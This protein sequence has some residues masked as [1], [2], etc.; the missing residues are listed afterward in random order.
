MVDIF[1][2]FLIINKANNLEIRNNIL[3]IIIRSHDLIKRFIITKHI[4]FYK[5]IIFPRLYAIFIYD[6]I[7]TNIIFQI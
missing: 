1:F 4:Q 5:K 2:S 6:L 3:F 7:S